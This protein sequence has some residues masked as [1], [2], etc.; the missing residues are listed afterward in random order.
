MSEDDEANWP[1]SYSMNIVHYAFNLEVSTY[2][3]N[4]VCI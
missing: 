3:F 1:N 2:I 4:I